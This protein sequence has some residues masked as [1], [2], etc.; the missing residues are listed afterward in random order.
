M[1]PTDPYDGDNQ[2]Y[3][4]S[5]PGT[6]APYGT[7]VGIDEE[8]ATSLATSQASTAGQNKGKT[9]ESS[10]RTLAIFAPTPRRHDDA[11]QRNIEEELIL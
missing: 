11:E 8:G 2:G 1:S 7:P 4:G 6:P 9:K 5:R 10:R 3:T